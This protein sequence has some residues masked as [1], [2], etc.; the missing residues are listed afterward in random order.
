MVQDQDSLPSNLC[1]D[2]NVLCVCSLVLSDY[3]MTIRMISEALS[4]GMSFVHGILTGNLKMKK[5][6]GAKMVLKLATP[7]QKL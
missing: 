7:E 3:R 1:K 5:V 4:L 2:E 6:W